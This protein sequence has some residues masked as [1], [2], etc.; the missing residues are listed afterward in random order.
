MSINRI[1]K[2]LLIKN[3]TFLV[4]VEHAD[5]GL[6]ILLRPCRV[7]E[8]FYVHMILLFCFELLF[9]FGSDNAKNSREEKL[10]TVQRD[11]LQN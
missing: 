1:N 6:D 3:N 4:C 9:D 5:D 7:E 10:L 8:N 11:I 2:A